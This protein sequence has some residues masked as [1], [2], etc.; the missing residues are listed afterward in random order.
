MR[1]IAGAAKGRKLDTPKTG[2]RPMTGRARESIFSILSARFDGTTVLD[3]YAG[4]GSLGLESLSRGATHAVFVEHDRD[5]ETILR[6]NVDRVGLG[7]LVHLADVASF[8]GE[9]SG[10]YNVVFV[11][12]PYADDDQQVR[13]VLELIEPVLDSRGIVVVHRQAR[14]ETTPPQFLRT[15]DERRYGDAV[16]TVMERVTE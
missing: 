7:G 6:R 16:V 10:V 2:T 13:D 15:I 1:I 5:A 3:L 12:P 14:S 9:R 4:S 8:L 11:D